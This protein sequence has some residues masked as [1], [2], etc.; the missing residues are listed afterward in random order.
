MDCNVSTFSI[1]IAGP[2]LVY[3]IDLIS[4]E[5]LHELSLTQKLTF[6]LSGKNIQY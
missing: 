6:I 3:N 2:L 5:M 1:S 4:N